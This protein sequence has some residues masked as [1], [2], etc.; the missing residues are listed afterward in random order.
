MADGGVPFAVTGLRFDLQ[1]EGKTV[2]AETQSD[3]CDTAAPP[4]AMGL[5]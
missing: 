4:D 5:L 3:G 1:V 2:G